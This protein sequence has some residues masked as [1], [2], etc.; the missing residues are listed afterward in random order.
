[1]LLGSDLV[2]AAHKHGLIVH[3]FTFRNP[4]EDKT[5]SQF[6]NDVM[7]E[8]LYFM[9]MGID[10]FFT[11]WAGEAI[12]ASRVH[13]YLQQQ[14]ERNNDALKKISTTSTTIGGLPAV[15]PLW[16]LALAFVGGVIVSVVIIASFR[17][18]RQSITSG[19]NKRTS[20]DL[21]QQ[22]RPGSRRGSVRLSSSATSSSGEDAT[23]SSSITSLLE[24]DE[25]EVA[26]IMSIDPIAKPS[27][28]KH[29]A[30]YATHEKY[31][32]GRASDSD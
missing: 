5:L 30:S 6:G 20:N 12:C 26:V 10:G 11:E 16:S 18:I 23:L 31:R 8:Y 2:N 28:T 1:M 19:D 27:S 3:P 9:S 15:V 25:E 17:S 7:A 22:Y 24:N 4:Y 29:T 13:E 14:E 21:K 32:R